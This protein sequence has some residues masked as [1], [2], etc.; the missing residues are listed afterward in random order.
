MSD[1]DNSEDREAYHVPHHHHVLHHGHAHAHHPVTTQVYPM[2]TYD[3]A[4]LYKQLSAEEGI[5]YK[6]YTDSQGN[7]TIGLGHKISGTQTAGFVQAVYNQDVLEAEHDLDTHH[8]WWRSIDPVRQL[9]LMDMRFNMG[10]GGL[11]TFTH[12]LASMQKGD[13]AQA[14]IDMMQSKW[15]AQVGRRANFLQEMILTGRIPE[16]TP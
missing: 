12:F 4:Q 2:P 15:E 16:S 11:D 13:W 7:Q 1:S 9:V 3:P 5:R 10:E 6:I 8:P 14:G